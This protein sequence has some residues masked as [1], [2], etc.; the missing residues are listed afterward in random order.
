MALNDRITIDPNIRHGKPVILGEKS[1]WR[2]HF[3][4]IV[5]RQTSLFHQIGL[6][7]FFQIL[8]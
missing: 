6:Q 2:C 8:S 7:T 4:Q 5:F 1:S 3:L